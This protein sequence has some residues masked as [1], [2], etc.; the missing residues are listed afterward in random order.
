MSMNEH[1]PEPGRSG[2]MV[3]FVVGAALGAGL[4][5]MLAPAS[6]HE[7][8]RR[9][10][11]TARRWGSSVRDGVDQARE[12]LK[13]VRS[14]VQGRI[15]GLKEDVSTAIASGRNAYARER[16]ARRDARM[17]TPMD[18]TTKS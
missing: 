6:G 11:Q 1:G 9:L 18:A 8:R 12:R 15:G 3:G 13:D 14:D 4:A 10:G 5:L 17:D 2:A 16:D 7:T